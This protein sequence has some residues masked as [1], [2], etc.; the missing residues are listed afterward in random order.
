MTNTLDP[1][2]TAGEIGSGIWFLL[3]TCLAISFARYAASRA[4]DGGHSGH[5]PA[6]IVAAGALTLFCGGSAMRAGLSWGQYMAINNDWDT[7]L[8][9]ST[10]PWFIVS[11]VVSVIGAAWCIWVFAPSQWRALMTAGTIVASVGVPVVLF[12]TL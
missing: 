3:A 2:L 8:W 12:F 9:T 11:V 4:R 7:H 6:D 1:G 5:D 10:W